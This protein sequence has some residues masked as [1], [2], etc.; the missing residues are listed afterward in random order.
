MIQKKT[1]K[2]LQQYQA[3]NRTVAALERYNR[4]GIEMKPGQS[5]RYLV[6]NDSLKNMNRVRLDFE[7][8]PDYDE[9]FYSTKLIRA[10]ESVLSPFG[11]EREEIR[12]T[13]SGSRT[14]LIQ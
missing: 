7:E 13:V 9:A 4:H 3:Y 8:F 5:V 12:S 2:Y 11:M 10:A 1:S 6:Y 14:Q